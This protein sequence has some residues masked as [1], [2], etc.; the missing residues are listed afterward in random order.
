MHKSRELDRTGIHEAGQG[1]HFG[2]AWSAL[3]I[4]PDQF[5]L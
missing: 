4:A 2:E 1:I 5:D 3:F